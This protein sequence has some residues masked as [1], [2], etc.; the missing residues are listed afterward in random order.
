MTRKRRRRQ[1]IAPPACTPS[2]PESLGVLD[3]SLDQY[4]DR[5][6]HDP[7]HP[8]APANHSGYGPWA[9]AQYLLDPFADADIHGSSV[10][11]HAKR[12]LIEAFHYMETLPW[13]HPFWQDLPR[14]IYRLLLDQD[15]GMPINPRDKRSWWFR[16]A[17]DLVA[18]PND[19]SSNAWR[20]LHALGDFQIEWAMD[21]ALHV[22]Q[23]C[24][25]RTGEQVVA[26]VTELGLTDEAQAV[27]VQRQSRYYPGEV[28]LG[29]PWETRVLRRIR[30][31]TG[32][33][34]Q[35]PSKSW[36]P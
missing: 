11:S 35:A 32:P 16:I 4:Y 28:E 7:S 8:I 27:L 14:S 25:V 30:E 34:D 21:A 33:S 6:L 3:Q 26:L 29:W 10:W 13:D 1:V 24:G 15:T 9:Q 23:L 17:L 5:L 12:A 31:I 19:F 36:S 22:E 20:A 2:W 18:C